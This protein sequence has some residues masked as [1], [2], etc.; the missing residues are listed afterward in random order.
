MNI[1]SFLLDKSTV[2]HCPHD[3]VFQASSTQSNNQD[4]AGFPAPAEILIKDET[5]FL[6]LPASPPPQ[7]L[8]HLMLCALESVTIVKTS[9]SSR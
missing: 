7:P 6:F 3:K 2:S 4:M 5:S 1:K 8:L 9:R